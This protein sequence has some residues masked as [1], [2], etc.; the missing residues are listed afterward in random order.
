MTLL[1]RT[2][3]IRLFTLVAMVGVLAAASTFIAGRRAS[4]YPAAQQYVDAIER[5]KVASGLAV[6]YQI[7]VVTESPGPD[8]IAGP[9][10]TPDGRGAFL[11]LSTI[12]PTK[13][14]IYAHD[15]GGSPMAR[16]VHGDILYAWEVARYETGY[17][18][19]I[20]R[21]R[22]ATESEIERGMHGGRHDT[23]VPQVQHVRQH[24]RLPARQRGGRMALHRRRP[25]CAHDPGPRALTRPPT[26]RRQEPEVVAFPAR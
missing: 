2:S 9:D 17:G 14:A 19:P 13:V 21:Q 18:Y 26:H 12:G 23:A 5:E 15:L 20:V 10:A 16:V 22:V 6:H 24:G 7:G 25:P 4:A 3:R 11:F 8:R 1:S